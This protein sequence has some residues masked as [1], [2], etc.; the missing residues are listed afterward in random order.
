[1]HACVRRQSGST[2]STYVR[3]SSVA[4]PLSRCRIRPETCICAMH[5]SICH[6]PGCWD[7][8]VA[9]VGACS[10][11]YVALTILTGLNSKWDNAK[12]LSRDEHS[13]RPLDHMNGFCRPLPP[14]LRMQLATLQA[15]LYFFTFWFE[16]KVQHVILLEV[17]RTV[18]AIITK[19]ANVSPHPPPQSNEKKRD[20][21][22]IL[23]IPIDS[24]D[25]Q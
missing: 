9:T 13:T 16:S 19:W 15:V 21:K 5:I 2:R 8:A 7:G 10:C 17:M 4:M 22:I 23:A 3:I 11:V 25:S 18:I 14:P 24:R 6:M 20:E 12:N 1:M